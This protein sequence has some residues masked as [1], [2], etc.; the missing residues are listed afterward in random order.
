MKKVNINLKRY[1]TIFIDFDGVI[2]KSNLLKK[3]NIYTAVKKFTNKQ[4]AYEF[5]EYF[6]NNNGI[7]REVKIF[8]YFGNNKIAKKILEEYS[9]IN[10][11]LI[12]LRLNAGL[13]NFLEQV[14]DKDLYILSGGDEREIKKYLIK[15]KIIK[16]FKSILAGPL[17]KTQNLKIISINYPALFIGDSKYDFEVA[18]Y[19]K[20]D[21]IFM[22]DNNKYY[23]FLDNF[24]KVLITKNFNTLIESKVY[25]KN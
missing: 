10:E 25:E 1:N 9:K 3:D 24:S 20:L 11:N 5:T 15:K 4:T 7:T 18:K 8:N 19:F 12:S 2:C 23:G 22:V 14:K 13:I 21:F 17:S 6:I 16:Y